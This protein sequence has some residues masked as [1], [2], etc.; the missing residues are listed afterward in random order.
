MCP[1]EP[2]ELGAGVSYPIVRGTVRQHSEL[3]TALNERGGALPLNAS[4][5]CKMRTSAPVTPRARRRRPPESADAKFCICE[6]D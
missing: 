2:N 3:M 4:M 6:H 1:P 5:V